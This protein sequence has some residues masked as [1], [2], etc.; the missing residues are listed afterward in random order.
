MPHIMYNKGGVQGYKLK[1]QEILGALNAP[2]SSV[3]E[4][5]PNLAPVYPH[6]ATTSVS[7]SGT[8]PSP[9]S[10]EVLIVPRFFPR[11]RLQRSSL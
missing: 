6:T 2:S 9:I 5:V 1:I 11:S 7:E 8:L 4:G 3:G 10:Y